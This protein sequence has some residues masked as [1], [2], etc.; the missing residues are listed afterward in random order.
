MF[1]IYS[2]PHIPPIHAIPQLFSLAAQVLPN[3][4]LF[5]EVN[6][7]NGTQGR[8]QI[9]GHLLLHFCRLWLVSE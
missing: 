4:W 3:N 1:T 7:Y 2:I 8:L 6:E 9:Q 5:R